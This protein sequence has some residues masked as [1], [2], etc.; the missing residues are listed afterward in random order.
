MK[1]QLKGQDEDAPVNARLYTPERQDDALFQQLGFEQSWKQWDE[2]RKQEGRQEL[3]HHQ[4][5]SH[6]PGR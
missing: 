2:S 6:A 1:F 4:D 3:N 5:H